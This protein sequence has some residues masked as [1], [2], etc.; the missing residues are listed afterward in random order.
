MPIFV[1]L[2][3]FEQL[4]SYFLLC[5]WTIVAKEAVEKHFRVLEKVFGSLNH[6]NVHL[7]DEKCKLFQ[8]EL[9]YLGHLLS[10]NG[11]CR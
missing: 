8:V 4:V 11:I 6:H 10:A 7:N 5:G 9:E 2:E 1:L 3:Q